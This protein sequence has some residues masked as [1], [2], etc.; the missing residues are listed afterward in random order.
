MGKVLIKSS[1]VQPRLLLLMAAVANTAQALAW[2]VTITSGCDSC[3]MEGS[4]HYTMEA[5]DVRTKNFKDS[6]AKHSFVKAVI[7]RL[8]KDYQG[9]LEYEGKAN[10]HAHFEYD[11]K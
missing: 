1:A 4:R 7:T 2:D 5:L 11:P 10:E 8:G 9:I 6:A 3:H